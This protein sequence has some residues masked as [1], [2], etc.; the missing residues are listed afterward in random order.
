MKRSLLVRTARRLSVVLLGV[1]AS[2]L[3]AALLAGA[4]APPGRFLSTLA[5]CSGQML[6]GP[7]RYQIGPVLGYPNEYQ[8]H[9]MGGPALWFYLPCLLLV[10]TH[11][12]RPSL[13]TAWLSATGFMVW[14]AFA[15]LAF[16]AFEF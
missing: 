8:L 7:L 10:L 11:P 13:L 5:Y 6:F 12:I 4:F 16:V 3:P 1:A 14:Y 9:P 2:V 15:T